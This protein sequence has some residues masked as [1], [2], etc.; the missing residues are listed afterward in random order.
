LFAYAALLFMFFPIVSFAVT[1]QTINYQGILKDNNGSLVNGTVQMQYAL[2][3]SLSGTGSLWSE[4]HSAVTVT[5]GR[6]S[7]VLGSVTPITLPFDAQYYLGVT[8]GLDAEMI[9]RQALTNAPYAMRAA[10]A[11]TLAYTGAVYRWQVFD[12]FSQQGGWLAANNPN[13]FGGVSPSS[14]TDGSATANQMSSDKEVLRQL[15]TNKG[16]GGKNALVVSNVYLQLSSTTGRVAV[17]LFRIK[18]TTAN[19]VVWFPTFYF[20]NYLGW[21]ERA[22]IAVNGTLA[23][24]WNADTPSSG[25][26]WQVGLSIPANRTST[27]IFVVPSGTAFNVGGLNIQER[28]LFFAFVNNS[29]Q[30]PAGLEYVD[31]FDTAGG[32]WEQ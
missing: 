2:Y 21:G 13:L 27:V 32:G 5:N 26:S 30:L 3:S 9:P 18:N 1:P 10:K 19:P 16:Y 15:L 12:T 29:L 28:G 22:S 11:E 14:W 6:Y 7:V 25:T 4:L 24:A 17:A 23:W 31:D 8:V 20:T